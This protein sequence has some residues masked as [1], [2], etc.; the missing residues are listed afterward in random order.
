M[1]CLIRGRCKAKIRHPPRV[2][3]K[4]SQTALEEKWR[5]IRHNPDIF[6]SP[7]GRGKNQVDGRLG[8]ESLG[9][10]LQNLNE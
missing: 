9:P 10:T 1:A 7:P 4:K 2:G 8:K 6:G 5:K 3:G